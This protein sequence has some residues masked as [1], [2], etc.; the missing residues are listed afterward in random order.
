[1]KQN[2]EN[3]QTGFLIFTFNLIKCSLVPRP[4]EHEEEEKGPCTHCLR[5][6]SCFP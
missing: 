4:F 1:M 2:K 3:D 5:M 6:P